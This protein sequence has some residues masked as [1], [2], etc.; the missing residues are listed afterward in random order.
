[1]RHRA[2]LNS[3]NIVVDKITQ[4]IKEVRYELAKVSWPTRNQIIQ[5]TAIVVVLSLVM[6]LFLGL[7]D[8]V[9]EWL[10]NKFIIR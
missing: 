10:L 4:F 9:F 1:M 5:Y 2:F 3:K 8:F 6:A 7:L